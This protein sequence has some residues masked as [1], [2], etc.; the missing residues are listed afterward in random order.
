MTTVST[1]PSVTAGAQPPTLRSPAFVRLLVVDDDAAQLKLCRLRLRKQGF[2]LETASSAEEALEKARRWRPT[3]I[4]S[5]V[6]MGGLDGFGLCR[7]VR[8]APELAGVPVILLSAH[9][10]DDD[11]RELAAR[12][13]AS[14]LV[15]RTPDFSAELAALEDAL[16][17]EPASVA[18]PADA[19]VYEEQLRAT[20]KHLTAAMTEARRAE[21]RYR[22]LVERL[23]AVV[24]MAEPTQHGPWGFVSPQ[25]E[26]L[27]GYAATEWRDDPTLWWRCIHPDDRERVGDA[28]RRARE[29]GQ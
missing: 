25:I 4:M 19:A 21:Q 8:E 22:E 13:G 16:R 20:N 29:T 26:Q 1:D 6:V 12:V 5:D 23:P 17:G 15:E 9:F 18:A 3:V 11:D 24:Y 14:A 2:V 10:R 7:R 27:V 28:E